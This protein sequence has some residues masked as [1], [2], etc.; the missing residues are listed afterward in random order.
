MRSIIYDPETFRLTYANE[1]A[2][3]RLRRNL[4]SLPQ[5]SLLDVFNDEEKHRFRRHIA[6]VSVGRMHAHAS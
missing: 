1:N 5:V 3:R 4:E 6:P 2:R